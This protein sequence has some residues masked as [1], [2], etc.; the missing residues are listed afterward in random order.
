MD[1]N[2][3][4][5]TAVSEDQV[6]LP[7]IEIKPELVSKEILNAIIQEFV[8]REG[9]NYGEIEFSLESKVNQVERQIQKGD[10]KI[11]FD[12]NTESVTLMTSREFLK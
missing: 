6:L 2:N 8:L 7:P 12:P 11:V 10:V 3:D 5:K 1:I 9:T 4:F